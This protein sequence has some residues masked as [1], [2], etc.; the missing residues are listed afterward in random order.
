MLQQPIMGQ[1]QPTATHE[2]PSP[3]AAVA[4]SATDST[5]TVTLPTGEQPVSE[6]LPYI[7]QAGR[8]P[9]DSLYKRNL[10]LN[11]LPR[12]Y[13]MG[14]VLVSSRHASSCPFNTH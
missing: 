12:I 14:A 7:A 2:H 4:P 13:A 9:W 5:S 3:T 10:I 1:K 11:T 6:I 8:V